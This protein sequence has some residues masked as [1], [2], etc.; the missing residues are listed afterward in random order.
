MGYKYYSFDECSNRDTVFEKLGLLEEDR[1][2]EYNL[3]EKD[4]IK[5]KD[6]GLSPSDIKDIILIFFDNNII[7][8]MGYEDFED[9]YDDDYDNDE[10]GDYDNHNNSK[11]RRDYDDD[12]E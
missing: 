10:D 4:I 9:S 1:K 5:I 7:E 3:V 11:S 2:I 8:Y 6:I 12:D